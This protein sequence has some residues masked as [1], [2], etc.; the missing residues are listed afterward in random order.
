MSR[1]LDINR[2][3]LTGD[4]GADKAVMFSE[5]VDSLVPISGWNARFTLPGTTLQKHVEQYLNIITQFNLKTPFLEGV[6][7]PGGGGGR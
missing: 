1:L 2:S 4:T 5:G 3:L 6:G 7:R